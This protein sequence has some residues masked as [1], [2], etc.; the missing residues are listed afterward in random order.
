MIREAIGVL[1]VA[2]MVALGGAATAQ[3]QTNPCTAKNPCAAKNP[4][5][6]GSNV[7]GLVLTQPNIGEQPASSFDRFPRSQR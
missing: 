6:Q 5:A 1:T 4:V 2:G 3:A 7:R